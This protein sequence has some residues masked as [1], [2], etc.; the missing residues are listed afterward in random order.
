MPPVAGEPPVDVEPPPFVD[1]P[2]VDV[3]PPVPP[4]ADEPPV[5]VE[6]PLLVVF[7]DDEL[8]PQPASTRLIERKRG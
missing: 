1:E 6:P 8:E 4:F 2:P 7:V 5:D 3:A